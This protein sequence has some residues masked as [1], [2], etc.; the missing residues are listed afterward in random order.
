MANRFLERLGAGATIPALKKLMRA[1]SRRAH[2]DLGGEG[3]TFVAL[4]REY[5]EALAF[6]EAGIE[7]APRRAAPSAEGAGPTAKKSGPGPAPASP[8]LRAFREAIAALGDAA[9]E[10]GCD[11]YR[12]KPPEPLALALVEAARAF[13]PGAALALSRLLAA[14]AE[15]GDEWHRYPGLM[16]RAFAFYKACAALA[17]WV[18]RGR[19]GDEDACRTRLTDL[20]EPTV[21]LFDSKRFSELPARFAEAAA[22]LALALPPEPRI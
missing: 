5:E 9:R 3:E 11:P 13:D 19:K 8:A 2:P 6:L 7:P 1:A 4:R 18:R 21:A 22:A 16:N 14:L 20:A 10:A 12:W 17:A 15:S